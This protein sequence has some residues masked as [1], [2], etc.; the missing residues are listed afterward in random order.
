MLSLLKPS[1]TSLLSRLDSVQTLGEVYALPFPHVI[2]RLSNVAHFASLAVKSPR[3]LGRLEDQSI[4]WRSPVPAQACEAT[5]LIERFERSAVQKDGQ[6]W[7]LD[8][9]VAHADIDAGV[10]TSV[11]MSGAHMP[12]MRVYMAA[13]DQPTWVVPHSAVTHILTQHAPHILEQ[14]VDGD[15]LQD[16]TFAAVQFERQFRM[17]ARRV[18]ANAVSLMT[19]I[20]FHFRD[21]NVRPNRTFLRVR[22]YQPV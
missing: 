12:K 9:T 11:H 4:A 18:P 6:R 19:G 2:G 21:A 22:G 20:S 16:L 1:E 5:S 10:I 14:R 3:I 13:S 15:F 7:D 8:M 17:A